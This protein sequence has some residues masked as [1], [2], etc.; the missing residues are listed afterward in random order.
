MTSMNCPSGQVCLLAENF[1][2]V[3]R[4]P[5]CVDTDSC[6][7]SNTSLK[8]TP[9]RTPTPT[10]GLQT[11]KTNC[12]DTCTSTSEC[13]SG[14]QCVFMNNQTTAVCRNPK[15]FSS[16]SCVCPSSIT[17]ITPTTYTAAKGTE[18]LTPTPTS[19][20]MATS[21]GTPTPTGLRLDA[22]PTPIPSPTPVPINPPLT[23]KSF[24]D[25]SGKAPQKFTLSGTSD[26][27]TEID[28]QFSPDSVGQTTTADAKGAWR[29]ILTKSLS[30][31]NKELTVTARASD[32][33]ET[34]VKQSFTVKSGGSF[35]SLFVGFLFLALI[36]GVGFFIYQKQMNDQ[37]SLFS[38]FPPISSSEGT[39]ASPLSQET[40][41]VSESPSD[42]EQPPIETEN[43]TPEETQEKPE[44]ITT[45]IPEEKPPF[46]S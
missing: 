34:Q 15:C 23:I 12:D 7:C 29:Y 38:Q 4:N 17:T 37:S 11:I 24:T 6:S 46:S 42:T 28:I 8:S 13:K 30:T 2:W 27:F 39:D 36:G 32:G 20:A 5:A 18:I 25:R 3:C 19:I 40:P 22:L 43:I 31:G 9:T 1:G 35:F 26:P 45:T 21:S 41:I 14:Y 10:S 33:G 44:G 16:Q